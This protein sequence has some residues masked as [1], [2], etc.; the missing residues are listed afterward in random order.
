MELVGKTLP[1]SECAVFPHKGPLAGKTGNIKGI[2]AYGTWSA[3]SRHASPYR[4]TLRQ[5]PGAGSGESPELRGKG[6]RILVWKQE[7]IEPWCRRRAGAGTGSER[8]KS[9]TAEAFARASAVTRGL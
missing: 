3:K 5:S 8:E 1:A 6:L 4:R 7:F 2:C 9:V